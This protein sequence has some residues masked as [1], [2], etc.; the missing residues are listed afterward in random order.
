MK[1]YW[2]RVQLLAEILRTEGIDGGGQL[3]ERRLGLQPEVLQECREYLLRT[4]LAAVSHGSFS[5]AFA[6]TASGEAFLKA[7]DEMEVIDVITEAADDVDNG[8]Q[9]QQKSAELLSGQPARDSL[10]RF[11]V[12]QQ[13]EIARL[14]MQL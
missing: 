10:L 14:E 9:T 11:H 12:Q 8:L 13:G 6:V 5:E 2:L 7:V 3:R 1:E 4:G